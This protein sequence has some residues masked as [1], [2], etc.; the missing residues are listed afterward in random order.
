MKFAGINPVAQEEFI[1]A[2]DFKVC[3]RG[4]GSYYG[5]ADNN[6][7]VI[8]T[9]SSKEDKEVS[10]KGFCKNPTLEMII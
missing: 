5:T 6:K 9:E 4:D 1:E 10:V 8:G 3:Q 7:C 2:Y